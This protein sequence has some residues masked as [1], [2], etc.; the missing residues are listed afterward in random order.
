MVTL[1]SA[2]VRSWRLRALCRGHKGESGSTGR[3]QGRSTVLPALVLKMVFLLYVT[4][5]EGIDAGVAAGKRS[6]APARARRGGAAMLRCCLLRHSAE[7]VMGLNASQACC[8]RW[9]RVTAAQPNLK[10]RN[11]A[12]NGVQV[13]VPADRAA[14]PRRVA[15]LKCLV[16]SVGLG[17]FELLFFCRRLLRSDLSD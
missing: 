7:S 2:E 3:R 5:F 4:S 1:C 17:K 13:L 11:A 14:L 8:C 15:G 9:M 10:C 12:N 6:G 16:T